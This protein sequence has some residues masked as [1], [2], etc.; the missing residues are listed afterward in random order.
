M[1]RFYTLILALVAV[2]TL[3][4]QTYM[5]L[6][7][8]GESSRLT[9]SEVGDMTF[10][11]QSIDIQGVGYALSDIDSLVIMPRIDVI[12][13]GGMATVNVPA[14]IKDDIEVSTL[15]GHVTIKNNN[16]WN[17]VELTL[18]GNCNNGSLTYEGAFKSTIRLNGLS[19][20][21]LSGP[22][23]NI[24]NGKRIDLVLTNGTI[25]S[26]ADA[27]SG[28]HKAALY[29]R[30]HLEV[31]GGGSLTVKGNTGHAISSNEYMVLKKSTGTITIAGSVKDAIHCGQYFEMRG[32]T[33]AWDENMK[34]DGIQAELELMADNI[35]PKPE[36]ENTGNLTISG[37]SITGIMTAETAEGI[38]ADCNITVSGGTINLRAMGAGSRGMRCDKDMLVSE[39]AA[40]TNITI[41]AEGNQW[42]NPNDPADKDRCTGIRVKGNMTVN[43]GTVT[44]THTNDMARDIKVTGTYTLNGGNVT[45]TVVH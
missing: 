30:G 44:V 22:A 15:A 45:G 25:N 9:L 43:A 2:T 28:T 38:K 4:A 33:V 42:T 3:Q 26:L 14:T 20:T 18:S 31:E 11:G 32:G 8:G 21:S 5:R 23:L 27:T 7:K 36:P 12:W 41:S 19:L 10:N 13:K 29:C 17:E 37:G 6:W 39:D 1:K 34:G 40:P 16:L 35:T 24:Q